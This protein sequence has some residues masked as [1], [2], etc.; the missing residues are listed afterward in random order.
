MPERQLCSH[1]QE[2]QS[3]V[4]VSWSQSTQ[5]SNQSEIKGQG[6]PSLS[7]Y[8]KSIFLQILLPSHFPWGLQVLKWDFIYDLFSFPFIAI[9]PELDHAQELPGAVF[10][11][12][13]LLNAPLHP[14]FLEWGLEFIFLKSFSSD[15][16][17]KCNSLVTFPFLPSFF[18]PFLSS[19][20]I[21]LLPVLPVGCP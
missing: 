15:S 9:V 18:P 7:V 2:S 3:R 8:V 21:P 16:N 20:P 5:A 6:C 13:T 12:C 14:N 4:W 11:I 1:L 10:E 19:S 17:A